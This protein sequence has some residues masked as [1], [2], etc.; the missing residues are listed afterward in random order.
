M[1]REIFLALIFYS[2]TKFHKLGLEWNP[3][4]SGERIASHPFCLRF[5]LCN[6]RRRRSNYLT[7]YDPSLPVTISWRCGIILLSLMDPLC[8]QVFYAWD[9]MS[10]PSVG[11]VNFDLWLTNRAGVWMVCELSFLF[12][13]RGFVGPDISSKITG[14]GNMCSFQNLA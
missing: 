6:R 7:S 2:S 8:A 13:I 5:I 3:S 1:Q 11:T 10:S 12:F 9:P 4:F 14:A